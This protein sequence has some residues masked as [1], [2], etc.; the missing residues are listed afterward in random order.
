[1][2]ATDSRSCGSNT[3]RQH[4]RTCQC[5]LNVRRFVCT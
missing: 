3:T 2:V 5:D 1:V 4:M